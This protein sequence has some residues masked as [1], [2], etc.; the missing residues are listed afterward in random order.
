[1]ANVKRIS[2]FLLTVVVAA[3]SVYFTGK[4]LVNTALI[5]GVLGGAGRA[6][7]A[8]VAIMDRYDMYMTHQI[9]DALE[10]VLEIE[11]V[12]WL[13]DSDQVAP[14]PN[15][16][17][18]GST[19]DPASL[20]WLFQQAEKLLDGQDTLFTTETQIAEGTEVIY[21]LDDTILVITW[22]QKIANC[23][24]SF[25]EVKIADASQFRRFLSGGEYGSE[26]QSLTT[27]MASSV[28]AVVAS[29]GDFYANR[30]HG[31]IVYDRQVKRVDTWAIDTCYIDENGDMLFSY[32]GELKT[33]KE[34]QEFVDK[35]GIR[36]S[37]AFGPVLVENGVPR[38]AYEYKD[39]IIGEGDDDHARIA[40][41]QRD[42]LHYFI[43]TAGQDK[44]RNCFRLPPLRE[45]Q[46]Y[47][48][49]FGCKHA[50]TLDG[51]QTATLVMNNQLI[52]CVSYDS[53]RYISDIIYFATAIPNGD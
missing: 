28:N 48:V 26:I 1:M 7:G 9:S 14:K 40:L 42:D 49:G 18:S 36:F 31:V 41:C 13:N 25:S 53:E 11:K 15:E 46:N 21:Y 6:E 43:V 34:A 38:P 47:V 3:F 20:E 50:Y 12:Y 17:C 29:S 24:Y 35:N 23:M 33:Q 5:P 44:N 39:Y 37:L 8:D 52:N 16:A 2:I 19:T 27:E 32:A 4:L 22:K 30:R 45:F 51:G 10:G